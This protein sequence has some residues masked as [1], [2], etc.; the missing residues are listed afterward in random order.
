MVRR[1]RRPEATR[2]G[3]RAAPP[4][5]YR[6]GARPDHP[7]RWGRRRRRHVVGGAHGP[8]VVPVR[9]PVVRRVTRWCGLDL[10]QRPDRLR[11]RLQPVLGH[12]QRAVARDRR[13]RLADRERSGR[14][15][16]GNR[17]G[18][19]RGRGRWHRTRH[20][21]R[22]LDLGSPGSGRHRHGTGFPGKSEFPASCSDG[23]IIHDISDVATDPDLEWV[24]Q[25]EAGT[26]FIANGMRDGVAIRVVIRNDE[27]ISGSPTNTSKNSR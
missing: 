27:I 13:E 21:V 16:G 3:A 12:T 10:P 7:G 26:T 18:A 4:G 23:R 20:A 24:P 1:R 5:R 14:G 11:V 15:L 22:R 9:C 2:T 6:D 19:V 25:G 17:R 8:P